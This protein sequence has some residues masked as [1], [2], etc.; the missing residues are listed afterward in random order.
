MAQNKIN[1]SL[2]VVIDAKTWLKF[3]LLASVKGLDKRDLLTECVEE[4]VKRH[5]N[6]LKK[7]TGA[8]VGQVG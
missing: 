6:E 7:F 5:E 3:G 4:Y 2:R 1:T 8:G